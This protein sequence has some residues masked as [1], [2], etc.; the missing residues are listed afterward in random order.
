MSRNRGF[1]LLGPAVAV[2]IAATGI[3]PLPA[4]AQAA[5]LREVALV[6]GS[7]A[8]EPTPRAGRFIGY[9]HP[10]GRN[11]FALRLRPALEA[12]AAGPCE[13]VVAFD[14]SEGQDGEYRAKAV[15][16]LKALLAG[17]ATGDRVQLM[18][19][20]HNTLS[21]TK[22]FTSPDGPEISKALEKLG[23]RVPLGSIDLA[24]V[25]EAVAG[26]FRDLPTKPRALVYFGGGASVG[27][28]LGSIEFERLIGSLLDKRIAVSSYAVGPHRNMQL[29]DAM[30]NHTGGLVVDGKLAAG[31]AGR[32]LAAAAHGRVAWP[33]MVSWPSE[34]S[35][36]FP[37]CTPPL[38]LDRDSLVVGTYKGTGPFKIRMTVDTLAGPKTLAW[39]V[40]PNKPDEANRFLVQL[41][42][43]ARKDE[44]IRLS[45]KLPGP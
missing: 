39:E 36:V 21:L 11:Y 8:G 34:F 44:G 5:G 6:I 42:A 17:L 37:T 32:D 45:Y 16:A 12:S 28:L 10:E 22:G 19:V 9:A 38:R 41:V 26:G 14:T 25:L 3:V 40:L 23:R 15:A 1:T 43:D 31:E 4:V 27:N 13:V 30:A 24:G 29:L 20:D 35:R 2:A 33:K 7:L 18:A